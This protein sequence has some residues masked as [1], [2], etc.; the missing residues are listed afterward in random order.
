MTTMSP[1]SI[2]PIRSVCVTV[3]G[4][5]SGVVPLAGPAH[6][7]RMYASFAI[8]ALSAGVGLTGWIRGA[9]SAAATLHSAITMIEI[10]SRMRSPGTSAVHL[11][12]SRGDANPPSDEPAPVLADRSIPRDEPFDRAP[13]ACAVCSVPAACSSSRM[14][15]ADDGH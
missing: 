12:P 2:G 3:Y 6:T 14:Q 5:P 1:P 15:V 10:S 4:L 7:P 8:A 13:H 11:S 9:G